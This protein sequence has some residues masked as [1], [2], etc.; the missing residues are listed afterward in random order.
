MT[1]T[2]GVAGLVPARKTD[3]GNVLG[4]QSTR[5][6]ALVTADWSMA[7]AIE[8]K[9]FTAQ[10]GTAI[11]PITGDAYDADQPFFA[12]DVS[13]G[14]AAILL[15]I[16]VY[17]QAAVGVVNYVIAET[18]TAKVGAG[19]STPITPVNHKSDGG[20]PSGTTAYGAYS[21]DGTAATGGVEFWH[22]GDPY[23]QAAGNMSPLF[24]WTHRDG[25][26]ILVNSSALLI[27][28]GG[29][30][31]PTGYVRVT[32]VEAAASDVS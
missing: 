13:A 4:I 12:L 31:D 11:T 32:Y 21:G 15:K 3:D 7:R 29:G 1:R 26:I 20:S 8:G 18:S 23:I 22:D 9:V 30:T 14:F 17:L 10:L 28:C 27:H 6:G 24:V 16:Q 19:T 5:D 25:P 2:A